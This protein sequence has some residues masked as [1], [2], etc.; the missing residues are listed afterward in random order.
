MANRGERDSVNNNAWARSFEFHIPVM[1][2]EFW[3]MERTKQALNEV[4]DVIL[5]LKS[6]EGSDKIGKKRGKKEWRQ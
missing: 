5:L 4:G 3:N 6:R 2:I 1:D